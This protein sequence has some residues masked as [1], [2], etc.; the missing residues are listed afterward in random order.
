MEK[1]R[2]NISIMLWGRRKN[3]HGLEREK[4]Y[5]IET[6]LV[7][8]FTPHMVVAFFTVLLFVLRM[9]NTSS[10]PCINKVL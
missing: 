5:N 8:S 1:A 2:S 6:R 4:A 3:L 9:S 7:L 10:H